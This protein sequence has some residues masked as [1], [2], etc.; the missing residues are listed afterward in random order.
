MDDVEIV[1]VDESLAG[2]R[3]DTALA[4]ALGLPRS[5]VARLISRGRVTIGDKEI[6]KS[7][8]VPLGEKI[9][10]ELEAPD[11]GF[12]T[13]GPLE[14]LYE[15]DDIVVVNKPVGMA[16]H[17]SPGWEGPTVLKSLT[18][19]GVKVSDH[20]PPER[21]GIVSRLDV[22]TSGGM[23]VA[24]SNRAYSALKAAFRDREVFRRYHALV[25][26]H[27]DPMVGTI[28]A[29]IAR[30]P[31]KQWKMAVVEGG[32]EAITHYEVIEL[33]PGAALLDVELETGRTH[34]IRVHMSAANHPCL[35]DVFYGADPVRGEKL[36]LNRQWLHARQIGFRHPATGEMMTFTAP[37]PKDLEDSL[38][39]MREGLGLW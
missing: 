2:Q 36:G 22:G 10:V 12:E 32:R 23:V 35:G 38:E 15:D 8:K 28:D 4:K 37:Y 11:M 18:E 29:P 26:G 33:M 21:K 31:S 34:Q 1:V 25:E 13:A 7:L 27:P 24:K 14:I 17:T 16:A 5:V 30:H 9:R 19:L 3:A 6:N 20:G 39:A